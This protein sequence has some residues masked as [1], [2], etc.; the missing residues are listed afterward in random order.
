MLRK[1]EKIGVCETNGAASINDCSIENGAAKWQFSL[2]YFKSLHCLTNILL[3]QTFDLFFQPSSCTY[4]ENFLIFLLNCNLFA[5]EIISNATHGILQALDSACLSGYN[6][7]R[8][9][10]INSHL[11]DIHIVKH[12]ICSCFAQMQIFL[13]PNV[14]LISRETHFNFS[15]SLSLLVLANKFR[16]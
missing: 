5:L 12:F 14:T 15:L 6:S 9:C 13:L 2:V 1:R 4:F 16:E 7:L 3:Y 10:S 11:I 8:I